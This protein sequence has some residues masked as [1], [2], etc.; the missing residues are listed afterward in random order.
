MVKHLKFNLK[1]DL[2]YNFN[3]EFELHSYCERE[4]IAVNVVRIKNQVEPYKDNL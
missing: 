4:T 1:F 2:K 3:H